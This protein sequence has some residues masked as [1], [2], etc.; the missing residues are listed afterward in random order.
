[1]RI[2]VLFSLLMALSSC[3]FLPFGYTPI[4]DIVSNPSRFEGEAI[5]VRGEV[6]HITKLPLLDLKSYTLRDDSGEILVL[7]EGTLPAL[8]EETAIRAQVKTIA[9]IDDQTL[10]LRLVEIEKLPV[11]G[12]KR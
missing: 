3:D 10:G 9:I 6:V 11:L 2:I 1:M 5:K 8:H 4:G 12:S 7:T